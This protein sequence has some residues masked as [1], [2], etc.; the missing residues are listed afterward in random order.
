MDKCSFILDTSVII[1][2]LNKQLNLLEYLNNFPDCEVY[3]NPIIM[4]EVLSKANMSEQEEA[5]ARS[6]L[7]SIKMIEIDQLTCEAAIKIRRTKGLRLPDAL[8]AASSIILNAT[9]LSNDS[10]LLD[11]QYTSYKANAT[12]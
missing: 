3:I 10:H 11:F 7:G 5:A 1:D 4:I 12:K 6:L 9:V 8:I 2:I